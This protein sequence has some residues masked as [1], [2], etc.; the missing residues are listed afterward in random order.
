VKKTFKHN[1]SKEPVGGF[2]LAFLLLSFSH[3]CLLYHWI[4]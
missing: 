4:V 1:E 2:M 3:D